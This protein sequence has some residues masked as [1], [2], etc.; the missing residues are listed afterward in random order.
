[1]EMEQLFNKYA[2]AF[3]KD[4]YDLG[5]TDLVK[6]SIDIGDHPPA[7][8][9]LRRVPISQRAVIDK[10]VD[11]QLRQGIIEP[12]QSPFAANLVIVKKSDGST[13]ACCDFRDL[14][15]LSK[16]DCYPFHAWINAWMPSVE[17]TP[18]SP[19][20]TCEIRTTRWRWSR[21]I[22]TK[23][24]SYVIAVHLLIG[25]CQWV[26]LTQGPRSRD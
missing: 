13:R 18:S 9:A 25:Q 21:K 5:W 1:M 16:R 15:Q 2:N 26:S 17:A 3:S 4:E 24:R 11:E 19:P 22:S 6:H 12:T 23:R 10:H 20:S 7:R 8:Q 14:N